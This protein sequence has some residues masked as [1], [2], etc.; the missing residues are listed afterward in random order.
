[1]F[2]SNLLILVLQLVLECLA[3]VDI[4]FENV[5]RYHKA[6]IDCS[7][8]S[9]TELTP[10]EQSTLLKGFIVFNFKCLALVNRDIQIKTDRENRVKESEDLAIQIAAMKEKHPELFPLTTSGTQSPEDKSIDIDVVLQDIQGKIQ[11]VEESVVAVKHLIDEDIEILV[12][13]LFFIYL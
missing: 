7:K 3:T 8:V 5:K 11:A 1:M 13:T 9:L 12:S 10:E 4:P 6:V 2:I